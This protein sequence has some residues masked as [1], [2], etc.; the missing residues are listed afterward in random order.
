LNYT[1][2]SLDKAAKWNLRRLLTPGTPEGEE[3]TKYLEQIASHFLGDVSLSLS[4]LR[5]IA[6]KIQT[7]PAGMENETDHV[8]TELEDLTL[9]DEK[10]VVKTLSHNT[11]RQYLV[12]GSLSRPLLTLWKTTPENSLI[13]TSPKKSAKE[14]M[15]V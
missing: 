12:S 3:R 9:E 6:E 11:A 2:V 4:S 10:F 7:N 8:S 1:P 13:G 14:L 15:S 5:A